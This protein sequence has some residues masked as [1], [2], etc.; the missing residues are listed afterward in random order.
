[1]TREGSYTRSNGTWGS[2]QES[3]SQIRMDIVPIL[4][5]HNQLSYQ[6]KAARREVKLLTRF[7]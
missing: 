3:K 7:K 4:L 5:S 1:M 6:P 2:K